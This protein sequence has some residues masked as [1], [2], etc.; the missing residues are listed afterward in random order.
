MKRDHNIWHFQPAQTKSPRPRRGIFS[1]HGSLLLQPQPLKIYLHSTSTTTPSSVFTH[2]CSQSLPA[3]IQSHSLSLIGLCLCIC[4]E[5]VRGLRAETCGGPS[6]N[7]CS[8]Q[9]RYPL[10]CLSCKDYRV[11]RISKTSSEPHFSPPERKPLFKSILGRI[12][13]SQLYPTIPNAYFS[14]QSDVFV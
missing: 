5:L 9:Q 3:S 12:W 13:K 6:T 4:T 8:R 10:R 11:F 2:T 14:P 7:P 1:I